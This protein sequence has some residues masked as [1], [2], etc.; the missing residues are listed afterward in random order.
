VVQAIADVFGDRRLGET[1]ELLLEPGLERQH[2]SLALFLANR[3]ALGGAAAPGRLLDAA[4]AVLA[5][6]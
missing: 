5:R 4:K 1:R 2:Q 6:R 3:A